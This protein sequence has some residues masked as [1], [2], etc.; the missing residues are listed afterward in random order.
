[1]SK[2]MNKCATALTNLALPLKQASENINPKTGCIHLRLD[3]R[4]EAEQLYHSTALKLK[5]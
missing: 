5:G 2:M 1:M 4:K 3:E